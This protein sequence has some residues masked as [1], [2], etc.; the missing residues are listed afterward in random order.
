M[1]EDIIQQPIIINPHH[2]NKNGS[3]CIKCK[4]LQRSVL[5]R[6]GSHQQSTHH[7]RH[8]ISSSERVSR[9]AKE[10][11]VGTLLVLLMLMIVIPPPSMLLSTVE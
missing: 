6:G 10:L 1:E 11:L 7:G 8:C 5:G 4:C 2:P 9:Q 3:Y